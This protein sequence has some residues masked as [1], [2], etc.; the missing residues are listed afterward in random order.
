MGRLKLD[1]SVLYCVIL[2]YVF[3]CVPPTNS[4][5]HS[6]A[7]FA[8]ILLGI[9]PLLTPLWLCWSHIALLKSSN[10]SVPASSECLPSGRMTTLGQ[11]CLVSTPPSRV[12]TLP[13]RTKRS[14]AP[15]DWPTPPGEDNATVRLLQGGADH[16]PGVGAGGRLP[17]ALL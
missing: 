17:A 16:L 10:T 14:W 9:V 1:I 12:G 7:N 5:A 4:W 15:F 6:F 2:I 3:S 8:S 11:T 13:Q